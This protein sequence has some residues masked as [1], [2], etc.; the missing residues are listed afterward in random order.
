MKLLQATI[1]GFGKCVDYH[2]DF[3]SQSFLTIY[4]ENESGKT[5]MQRF[6]LFMLFG[7]PPKQRKLY[8]PKTSSRMGGSLTVYDHEVGQYT[9][10]R[11]ADTRNGAAICLTKDGKEYDETWLQER[12]QG[13][14]EKT[15]K[16]IYSFSATDLSH[17]QEI[18]EE[19][20]SEVL[21]GIGLTGSAQIHAIEKRLDQR[22]SDYFKP[23]GK[24]PAVNQQLVKLEQLQKQLIELKN[25]EATYQEKK[26]AMVEM[27]KTITSITQQT[28]KLKQKQYELEKIVQA[29]PQI[30]AYKQYQNKLKELPDELPFPEEGIERL[31]SLKD[32]QY[33]IQSEIKVL[34][35]NKESLV[36]EKNE[37]QS[38]NYKFPF[39]EAVNVY[40]KHADYQKHQENL[41]S[42]QEQIKRLEEEINNKILELNLGIGKD[43]LE[44]IS[45]PFQLEHKWSEL[46]RTFENLNNEFE[47][48][49]ENIHLQQANQKRIEQELQDISLSLL[50]PDKRKE[51]EE[52]VETYKEN[53]LL[54]ALQK[55]KNEQQ[56]NWVKTKQ[57]TNKRIGQFLG[58]SI[59]V[60]I[61]F[62]VLAFFTKDYLY[63]TITFISILLG[64]VQ[65]GFGK[66]SIQNME[67]MLNPITISH[68]SKVVITE[69]ER[70]KAAELLEMHQINLREMELLEDKLRDSDI[71]LNQLQEQKV[72]L[73]N[74]KANLQRDIDTQRATYPFLANIEVIYWQELY[75]ALKG[76]C[77]VVSHINHLKLRE[78]DLLKEIEKYHEAV[79]LFFDTLEFDSTPRTIEARLEYL[80]AELEKYRDR[81]KQLQQIDKKLI[82]VNEDLNELVIQCNTLKQEIHSLFEIAKVKDEEAYYQKSR[83]L[84]EQRELANSCKNIKTQFSNYFTEDKWEE[85]VNKP[86][87]QNII[88]LDIATTNEEIHK[89]E[90]EKEEKRQQLARI[91]LEFQK[92]ESSEVYS[93]IMHMFESEKE[94]L[95][96]LARKW[97]VHKVA[98]ELLTE[99]KGNFRD[100]YLTKVMEKTT[101]FFQLITDNVYINV[102]PPIEEKPFIV[103]RQDHI[104]FHVQELSQGTINQLYVS[105]RLAI[106]MVMSESLQMPFIMDDAFVHFDMIRYDRMIQ[107]LENVSDQHQIL[108]F[109][110]KQDLTSR[111]ND[112][113][114][115]RL[116][117]AVPIVEN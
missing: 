67:A 21:L 63:V 50:T 48:I 55:E 36:L 6:I 77:K 108:L 70:Q 94:K 91:T 102:F 52:I 53:K 87:Q 85:L 25:E 57:Q 3:K 7:L 107:I 13:I 44:N 79:D 19:N 90:E 45:L 80:E 72:L 58:I 31:E 92:L 113:N 54:D 28:N 65:W 59:F 83:E 109:T 17:L 39:E 2:I 22:I 11:L 95:A 75:H 86:P 5:T 115:L 47:T 14:N 37:L 16:A 26:N 96:N 33:P 66:K 76:I 34:E 81:E 116:T 117:N 104:R 32:K 93:Q 114:L 103:E 9:I 1:Y 106:S 88:E 78:R 84:M 112:K 74:R 10:E 35:K 43:E 71:M 27:E 110:C 89:L 49:K 12:L 73:E 101:Y 20:I 61:F 100:K 64:L 99:T 60:G 8:Q 42:T 69:V 68:N 51:L 38:I 56:T 24:N 105:L 97:A 46:K 4:G 62:A 82:E 18:K 29:L 30:K 41:L 15:Y 23:Y 111:I 40:S 98:K